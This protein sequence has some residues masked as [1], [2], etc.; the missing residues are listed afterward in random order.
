M[1]LPPKTCTIDRLVTNE[2]GVAQVLAGRKTAQRRNGRYAD[3]GET[4]ELG[5]RTFRITAVYPQLLGE[6][7]EAQARA[8]GYPSMEA[9]RASI[10]ALHPGMPWVPKARVWVHE[11]QP[12]TAG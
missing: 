7:T 8:E 10:L 5:G 1:E 4:W 11:W 12:V 3:V 6:M 9:Y 2:E